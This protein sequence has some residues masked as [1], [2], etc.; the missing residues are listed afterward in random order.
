MIPSFIL[1]VGFLVVTNM[2][3]VAEV[4]SEAY[5]KAYSGVRHLT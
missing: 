4:Y 5:S 3:L 1:L 2:T